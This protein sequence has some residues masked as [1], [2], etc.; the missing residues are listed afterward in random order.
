M[1]PVCPRER[2]QKLY[3]SLMGLPADLKYAR[4]LSERLLQHRGSDRTTG[5]ARTLPLSHWKDLTKKT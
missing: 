5:L 2:R 1:M 4:E 3:L